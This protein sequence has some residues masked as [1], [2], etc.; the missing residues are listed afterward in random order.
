MLRQCNIRG[1]S[2]II[3]SHQLPLSVNHIF[4]DKTKDRSRALFKYEN[5]LSKQYVLDYRNKTFNLSLEEWFLFV[6]VESA[7]N[8][9]NLSV[10]VA[11]SEDDFYQKMVTNPYLILIRKYLLHFKIQRSKNYQKLLFI[12]K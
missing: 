12:L 1:I 9:P 7:I 2:V 6:L 8:A 3:K 5:I 10:P 4:N 11:L